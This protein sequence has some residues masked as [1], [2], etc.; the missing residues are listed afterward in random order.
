MDGF[1]ENKDNVYVITKKTSAK[2]LP[3]V[4]DP[5][6]NFNIEYKDFPE[7]RSHTRVSK[8]SDG[9]L[10]FTYDNTTVSAGGLITDS[11]FFKVFDFK[12]LIGDINNVLDEPDA[13]LLT[14]DFAKIIFGDEDPIG[15]IIEVGD[16]KVKKF[17][18]RG[19]LDKV[20]YNSSIELDFI[21]P[22]Q[23]NDPNFFSR[24]G[25]SFILVD[26][27]FDETLFKERINQFEDKYNRFKETTLDILPFDYKEIN[28]SNVQSHG[29]FSRIVNEN[30]L[31]IQIIIMLVIL[32]ISA[33]NFS[34]LQIINTNSRI[35]DSALKIV[36]GANKNHTVKQMFV[37]MLVLILI[38]TL[39]T[40]LAYV[41]VLPTFTS[42]TKIYLSPS[43]LEVIKINCL[44]LLLIATMGMIYPFI[45][46]IR[47]P[48]VNGLRN[49]VI[50]DRN[51]K[52]KGIIVV[53]QYTL[54]FL[55]LISSMVV[56]KQLSLMLDMDLGFNQKNIVSAQLWTIPSNIETRE[57]Y[58]KFL[59]KINL[60]KNELERNG[61]IKSFTKGNI[62]IDSFTMDW[63]KKNEENDLET[64]NMLQV[65][66][67]YEE[68]FNL[69][70]IE[71]RFFDNDIDRSRENK[72]VINEAAK[73]Y[74]N[75]SAINNTI[76]EH[77]SWGDYNIIGVVQDFKYQHL[78]SI[79]QP[80]IMIY[81][82]NVDDPYIVEFYDESIESGLGFLE[83]FYK[84]NNP[85]A[86]FNYTFLEDD[87][88]SLYQKEKQLGINYIL[89]TVIA[90]IISIIGLFTIAI[91]GTRR[92]VKE[93][94]VRKVNGAQVW[95]VIYLL[96]ISFI[97]WVGL[98]FIIASPIAY[99]LM[100]NWLQNF[101]YKTNISWWIFALAGAF[102]FIISLSTVSWQSYKAAIAN[103]VKSLRTE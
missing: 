3:E 9:E 28:K 54:A 17:T 22:R 98:A 32:T 46:G 43:L 25:G 38:C 16:R 20:P 85:Q 87:I 44:V 29:I 51:L 82:E 91:Y 27:S 66:P 52:G 72:I 40:T 31:Y 102:T 96:N 1:H 4:F 18:V 48:L 26:K 55:L 71:G 77:E 34:N 37:E 97:R 67:N 59:T 78:S 63:K 10:L 73:K 58:D 41:L 80:L 79:T 14:E 24:M 45:I 74:W 12:L 68:L 19:I 86:S 49:M 8:Y 35:K 7:L 60:G 61:N 42:L 69:K 36:N 103:P 5:T 83:N 13:I 21:M 70:L 62:P 6:L 53:F 57:D 92:R 94:A 81:M 15:K 47:V 11:L 64:H 75:I 101:A 89:F 84:N 93:I 50:N 30:N 95:E 90:L 76:M 100:Q 23:Y 56:A 39:I 65:S 99:L 88:A 2:S 33:L